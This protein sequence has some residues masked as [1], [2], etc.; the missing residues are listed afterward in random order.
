MS[1]LGTEFLCENRSKQ[2]FAFQF[3]VAQTDFYQSCFVSVNISELVDVKYVFNSYPQQIYIFLNP[4]DE[5]DYCNSSFYQIIL[6][7]FPVL[8]GLKLLL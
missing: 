1:F 7:L 5:K 4:F 2:V 3:T 6:F 8:Q